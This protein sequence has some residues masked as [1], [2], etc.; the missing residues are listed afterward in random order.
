MSEHE[1]Y[2]VRAPKDVVII[3]P[4]ELPTYV[5]DKTAVGNVEFLGVIF[6]DPRLG[7]CCVALSL[8]MAEDLA[9]H[10]SAILGDT[11]HLRR[12]WELRNGE[13]Q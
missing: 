7:P 10:V 2:G 13:P 3:T 4:T 9:R 12:E 8:S 11:E 5:F 6:E 1:V